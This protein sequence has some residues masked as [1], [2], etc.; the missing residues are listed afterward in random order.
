MPDRPL[1]I[2]DFHVLITL[3][4][5]PNHGYGIVKAIE[6][7]SRGEIKPAPGNLYPVLNR[8]QKAGLISATSDPS[9]K[10]AKGPP[11]RNYQITDQGILAARAEAQR[12]QALMSNPTL[13]GLLGSQ[14]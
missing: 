1:R 3:V 2:L 12:M 14:A 4:E 11:R 8:L 13:Q 9:E 6:E 7:R 5:A 10:T